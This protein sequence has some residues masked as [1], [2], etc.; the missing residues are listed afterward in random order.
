M[1]FDDLASE[2]TVSLPPQS[3]CVQFQWEGKGGSG[4]VS[5]DHVEPKILLW[6]F[7]ENAIC[8]KYVPFNRK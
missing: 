4:K 2:V 3:L 5:E 1:A 8:H 7:L 6:P